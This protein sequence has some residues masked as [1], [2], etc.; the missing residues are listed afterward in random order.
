MVMPVVFG[1]LWIVAKVKTFE[2]HFHFFALSLIAFA[3]KRDSFAFTFATCR[4]EKPHSCYSCHAGSG[5]VIVMLN[6]W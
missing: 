2:F 6:F 1:T 3:S 5:V 4:I